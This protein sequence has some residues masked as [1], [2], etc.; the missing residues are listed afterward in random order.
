MVIVFPALRKLGFLSLMGSAASDGL[1]LQGKK[2]ASMG[3][4]VTPETR[5]P[6]KARRSPGRAEKAGPLFPSLEMRVYDHPGQK[7]DQSRRVPFRITGISGKGRNSRKR[8]KEAQ[9]GH[10]NKA[11]YLA[12]TRRLFS[13]T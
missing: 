8:L 10:L 9:R 7:G 6:A 1:L 4:E 11:E 3:P 12:T 2:L 13:L 5:V